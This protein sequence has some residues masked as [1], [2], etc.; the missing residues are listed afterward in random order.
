MSDA[1][2]TLSWPDVHFSLT[3]FEQNLKET[4]YTPKIIIGV[5][6]G[7]LIPATLLA[8][9]LNV[10][11]V[12]N[13]SVQTYTDDNTKSDDIV[14][15]QEPGGSLRDHLNDEILIVDDLSDSGVTLNYIKMFLIAHYGLK[16]VK[17]AT[18]CIKDKTNFLPDYFITQFPSTTWLIFPWEI[19]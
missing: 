15:V 8:Y 17:T 18:L 16:K 9:K 2:H 12:Y 6:R 3:K 14:T 19:D 1:K 11:Q 4:Q 5:G 7:G 13:F 10:K